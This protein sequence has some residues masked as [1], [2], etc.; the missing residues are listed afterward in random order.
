MENEKWNRKWKINSKPGI[1]RELLYLWLAGNDEGI[2]KEMETTNVGYI[3]AIKA[4]IGLRTSQ[5]S[6][7]YKIDPFTA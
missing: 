7:D 5:T 6:E 3:G 2:E 4:H 1:C